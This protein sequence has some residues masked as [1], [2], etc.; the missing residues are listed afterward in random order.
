LRCHRRESQTIRCEVSSR[1][2]DHGRRRPLRDNRRS[3]K[4]SLRNLPAVTEK[5]RPPARLGTGLRPVQAER[6]LG[7][8]FDGDRQSADSPVDAPLGRE[9]KEIVVPL[10]PEMLVP[11]PPASR[12]H[13]ERRIGK[14]SAADAQSKDA[15]SPTTAKIT[16]FT[17]ATERVS[18]Q[19]RFWPEWSGSQLRFV[20]NQMNMLK[21]LPTRLDLTEECQLK[22]SW[23]LQPC[24]HRIPRSPSCLS[25]HACAGNL[26]DLGCR[27]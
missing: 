6:K 3:A 5:V 26:E 27:N 15:Y 24:V 22:V 13:P 9:R 21:K 25:K 1:T 14:Q 16:S 4:R 2:H 10:L 23:P 20:E 7:S 11:Q 12:C 18:F 8:V 17:G 19:T